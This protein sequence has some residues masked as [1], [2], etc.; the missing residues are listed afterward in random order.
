[1]YEV[2]IDPSMLIDRDY[3]ESTA[4]TTESNDGDLMNIVFGGAG[5]L[6]PILFLSFLWWR[7]RSRK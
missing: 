1:M 2:K 6:I 5:I 3:T 4:S 7:I